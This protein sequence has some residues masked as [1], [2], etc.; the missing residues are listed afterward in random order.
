MQRDWNVP[1]GTPVVPAVFPAKFTFSP[2]ATPDC[3]NDYVAFPVNVSG[4]TKANLIGF[5]NLYESR[6]FDS[7]HNVSQPGDSGGAL[8]A[9][10]KARVLLLGGEPLDGPRFLWWNFVSSRKERLAHAADDWRRFSVRSERFAAIRTQEDVTR[11]KP[12]PDLYLAALDGLHLERIRDAL[13]SALPRLHELG[14]SGIPAMM[15]EGME[16]RAIWPH[17]AL[18]GFRAFF[19]KGTV[20]ELTGVGHFIQ[21]DAPEIVVPLIEE[22]CLRT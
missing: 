2:Y 1:L 5:N 15:I 11:H 7:H 10:G 14:R 16:D 9:R 6:P 8:S 22:F 17:V 12:F 18:A 21:E 13:V 19:P 3:T 4:S 20:H